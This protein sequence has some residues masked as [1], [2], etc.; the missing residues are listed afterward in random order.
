MTTLYLA[1][2]G[3]IG[4]QRL[5]ELA[6]SERNARAALA[7]GGV[8]SGRR[9]FR[10]MKALH[11]A[12]LLACAGEVLLL[13]RP[14]HPALGVPMLALALAAQ[15]VRGWTVRALGPCWNAR[16]IVVPG[17]AV[18][19]TGPYRFLRHPNYLAVAVEGVAIPLVHGAWLTAAVFSLLDAAL[20]AVRI[21]CEERALEAHCP[22]AGRLAGLPRLIPG[23]R[24]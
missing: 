11:G 15:G 22:G 14:F 9:H 7:R 23:L 2:L 19:T 6:L 18:V 12:F 1:F 4:V 20:L 5:A 8:E 3:L 13:Q 21:R 16:V 17:S 24:V 10:F